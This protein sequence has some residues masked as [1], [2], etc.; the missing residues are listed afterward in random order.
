MIMNSLS[1]IL[2]YIAFIGFVI[3]AF[4]LLTN[5]IGFAIKMVSLLFFL[6][7]IDICLKTN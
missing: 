6:L 2:L 3:L 7:V 5:H 1:N 4:L